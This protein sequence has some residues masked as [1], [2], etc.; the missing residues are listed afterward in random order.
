[1]SCLLGCVSQMGVVVREHGLGEVRCCR[2]VDV[3][4]VGVCVLNGCV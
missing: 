4:S 3:L 2:L 1:M